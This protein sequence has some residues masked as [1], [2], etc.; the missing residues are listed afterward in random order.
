MGSPVAR[1]WGKKTCGAAEEAPV[2]LASPAVASGDG[3]VAGRSAAGSAPQ[4]MMFVTLIAWMIA[5]PKSLTS[6]RS[7]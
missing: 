1:S 4:A 5:F 6:G 7:P 2:D 3:V